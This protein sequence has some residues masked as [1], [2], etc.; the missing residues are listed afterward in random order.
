MQHQHTNYPTE[1][2]H[3]VNELIA[4]Y[5]DAEI[6]YLTAAAN[7][8]CEKIG[9]LP[10]L[11]RYLRARAHVIFFRRAILMCYQTKRGA[12]VEM[13]DPTNAA[14]H[15]KP[16]ESVKELIEQVLKELIEME[17]RVEEGWKKLAEVAE[18]H[19]DPVTAAFAKK[20]MDS[21]KAKIVPQATHI[22]QSFAEV[23]CPFTYDSTA[24]KEE[25]DE[26]EEL[27][28]SLMNMDCDSKKSEKC[29]QH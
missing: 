3:V 25:A 11:T 14:P 29:S 21:W 17:R 18:K 7:A 28:K 27:A 8:A 15:K 16:V 9:H 1:V 4:A 24:M 2:E 5:T 12:A 6:A 23:K 19:S 22:Y 10:N 13:V 26:Q 20:D